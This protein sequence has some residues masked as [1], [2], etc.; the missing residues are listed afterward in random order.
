MAQCGPRYEESKPDAAPTDFTT[1]VLQ[2]HQDMLHML[3]RSLYALPLPRR[4]T[5]RMYAAHT[6]QARAL[7]GLR[8]CAGHEYTG[9][10]TWAA[11]TVAST[12]PRTTPSRPVP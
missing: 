8:G 7:I 11:P 4:A 1:I 10:Q 6:E 5:L 2:M 12:V 3:E 9:E